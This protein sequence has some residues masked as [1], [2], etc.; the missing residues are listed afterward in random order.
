MVRP[1]AAAPLWLSGLLA[2]PVGAWWQFQQPQLWSA[3]AYAAVLAAAGLVAAAALALRHRSWASGVVAAA[4]ALGMYGLTGARA[5]WFEQS[6]LPAHL[7]G[8]DLLVEGWVA[9]LPRETESGYQFE[10]ATDQAW[11]GGQP[12]QLPPRVRLSWRPTAD[13]QAPDWR[14]GQR[15]RLTLRLHRPHGLSNPGGFDTELWMWEQG[16]QATGYV[17]RGR[18]VAEPIRLAQTWRYPVAQARQVVRDRLLRYAAPSPSAGI[19][20][21]LITG[22]QAAITATQWDVFR[23]TGVTHLVVV[24]GMHIT[25]FAWLAI[26]LVA[27]LWRL[28]GRRWPGWLLAVPTPVAS[29]VGGA[30]LALAYAVFSGWGVP[31]QRAA[32]MLLTVLALRLTGRRWPW[33]LMWLSVMGAVLLI[34]PWALLRAGFWLSFVAVAVLFAT[35]SPWQPSHKG[36]RHALWQMFRTQALVTVALAPLTLMWF[37]QFSLVGLVANLLAIPWVTLVLTPLALAGVLWAPLWALGGWAG[38]ALWWWLQALAVWPNAQVMRPAVPM[39][40]AVLGAVGGLLLVLRLPVAVRIWGLLLVW[41]VLVYAPPRPPLGHYEWVAPDVGQGTAVVVRT[42]HHTLVFD[43]GPPMGTQAT[44]AERVLLPLLR[45]AGES[46]TRVVISHGDSDHASGMQTL[47][48]AYPA[49]DWRLSF[50]PPDGWV[51]P[52]R[53][54][55]A[56]EVWE[57]D[58][59]RFAFLHPREADYGSR[60][61]S[62]AMSCV[63][64]VGPPDN[65]LLLTGDITV[66]EETRLALAQPDL[67]AR[68]LFAAHHGSHSSTGPVWLN[69]L[70]PTVVVVQSGHRNRFGHPAAEVVRRLEARAILWVNSPECGAATGHSQQPDRVHCHRSEQKRYW[71]HSKTP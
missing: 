46:P 21:A 64:Q 28:L 23:I 35:A 53:P 61:S 49:A 36:W 54:C 41:P 25:L 2:I 37:G 58:G 20:A 56:G 17:R 26:T 19:L 14:A 55:V 69:R 57:W 71:H 48:R 12:V 34:D 42:R 11:L 10:W 51:A 63:L 32:L 6:A 52:Q 66:A 31:A 70:Q 7:E 29:A 67:R 1:V 62:N 44:A 43:S 15:W 3:S 39:G 30:L 13:A 18:G 59:V 33:P 38:D 5:V 27:S 8:Q 9:G 47:A 40:M 45:R 4:V 22:D 16:L 65:T 68:V 60:L 50:A 24:S